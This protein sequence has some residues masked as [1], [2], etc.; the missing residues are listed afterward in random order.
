MKII[1]LNTIIVSLLMVILINISCEAPRSSGNFEEEIRQAEKAFNDMAAEQGVMEAFLAFA[2]D[3][4]VLNRRGGIVKGK[5]EIRSYFESQ[6]LQ[7]VS[8][9][10]EPEFIDVSKSGDMAYTYGPFTF[11]A[12]DTTGQV[13]ESV[14]VFHT[15]W[16]RQVDGSWKFVYD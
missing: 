14:G 2:A 11:S 3:D 7:N 13:I 4:G 1:R 10:W 12:T 8:L 6:T 9:Q 5:E 16:K 15:V